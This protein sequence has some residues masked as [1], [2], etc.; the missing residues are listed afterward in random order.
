MKKDSLNFSEAALTWDTPERTSRAEQVAGAMKDSL[1]LDG[2]HTIMRGLEF[3]CGTG[4][5]GFALREYIE[6]LSLVDPSEGMIA[7]VDEKIEKLGAFNV[8]GY[9]TDLIEGSFEPQDLIFSSMALH[10]ILDLKPL[11]ERI[12][13]ML[14]LGG[15][16][17][18]VDLD[19]DKDGQ[20]HRDEAGF[21][22]HH[23]FDQGQLSIELGNY[24]LKTK[25]SRTFFR[26]N[27]VKNGLTVPYSLFVLVAEKI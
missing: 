8:K 16:L 11:F 13:Q 26:D 12:S 9:C 6:T 23:G 17:C 20:F 14:N 10:H 7:V 18:I 22:G 4:L 2:S 5:V 3:G 24:G 19:L 1:G 25:V 21:D 27:K 15:R